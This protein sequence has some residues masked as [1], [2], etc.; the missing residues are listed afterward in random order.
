M[1]KEGSQ[2]LALIPGGALRVV[3]SSLEGSPLPAKQVPPGV[4]PNPSGTRMLPSGFSPS[5]SYISARVPDTG[6]VTSALGFCLDFCRLFIKNDGW[7]DKLLKMSSPATGVLLL[8]CSSHSHQLAWAFSFE[9]LLKVERPDLLQVQSP[10]NFNELLLQSVS[11][12]KP[13]I[14]EFLIFQPLCKHTHTYIYTEI[15]NSL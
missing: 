11:E 12:E 4:I 5:P 14:R 13:R 15:M 8:G 2:A 10:V 9:L 7:K 3:A 6:P 1:V